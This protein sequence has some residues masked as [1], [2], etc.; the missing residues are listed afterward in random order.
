M[1]LI[2]LLCVI[3]ILCSCQSEPEEYDQYRVIGYSVDA[4]GT[5]MGYIQGD[6][7]DSPCEG[8]RVMSVK[9]STLS[10]QGKP[11]KIKARLMRGAY[12]IK[13]HTYPQES[14]EALMARGRS[15]PTGWV[16]V[17]GV[18]HE[19][20]FEQYSSGEDIDFWYENEFVVMAK[21]TK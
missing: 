19:I 1:R 8:L 18:R 21:E 15:L 5:R 6:I 20:C 13:P 9:D 17:K 2:F 3:W 14:G 12:Y 11:V 10:V 4:H 7:K 16:E